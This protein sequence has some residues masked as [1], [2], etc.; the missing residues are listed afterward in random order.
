M[1]MEGE[2]MGERWR[3]GVEV[4]LVIK[5]DG[6]SFSNVWKRGRPGGES[7][8][9]G[10]SVVRPDAA[11][12]VFRPSRP[13]HLPAESRF[14]GMLPPSPAPCVRASRQGPLRAPAQRP[15]GPVSPGNSA[16]AGRRAGAGCARWCGPRLARVAME[17]RQW[18]RRP[19]GCPGPGRSRAFWGSCSEEGPRRPPQPVLL[20]ARAGGR[21]RRASSLTTELAG[22]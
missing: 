5:C 21:W 1:S 20:R 17:F 10:W 8:T 6:A 14:S 2:G 12:H 13:P 19:A 11:G 3:W 7:K 18:K 4:K 16:A 22:D 9:G 15:T